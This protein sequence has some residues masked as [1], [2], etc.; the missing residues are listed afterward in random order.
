MARQTPGVVERHSRSCP[1]RNGGRCVRPCAPTF[2]A[3]VW[4]QAEG[5]KIRRSFPT[6]AAAKGWRADAIGAVR[7]GT[8]TAPSRQTVGEAGVEFIAKARRGE[9]LTR[10]GVRYKPAVVREYERDLRR[11]VAPALG[12]I[13]LTNLRK[14]DVQALVDR[15]VAQGLSGSTVRNVVMPL[16]VIC[17]F[18]IEND[19]LAVN[20]MVG[21]RLPAA[22][23]RRERVATV[24]ESERLI[25]ALP[26][27]D[28][29]LWAT[30]FYAG[31]RRGELRAIRWED[32]ND[33]VT[34]LTVRRGWDE[35]EGEIAPKSQKG[36][37]TVP[38]VPL[39]RRLLLEH[40]AR[41]GRRGADLVFGRTAAEP[42]TPTHI[43]NRALGAW[44][45]AAIG[46]FFR[47]RNAGLEPIALHECRHTYVSLMAD[48]GFK[49]EEIGDYVGHSSTFMVD[50]YRHL[51]EGHEQ[52]A[53]AR[54]DRYLTERTGARTGAQ[55]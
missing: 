45:A 4:S 18:A 44:A 14:R 20:P 43:R 15:L 29:P 30:A 9:A 48:A 34:V 26:A 36:M 17:R 28:R 2:E 46:G 52:E 54:F 49:L 53:A 37:R 47:G 24:D 38:I 5:R 41:T 10:G 16:R 25:D 13:R 12:T 8:M 39:L 3:W 31:L 23:G 1:V 55:R 27:D 7:R 33:D 50:R 22:A 51:I 40:K 21:L 11:Y 32:V 19:E 6:I 35:V 42:F